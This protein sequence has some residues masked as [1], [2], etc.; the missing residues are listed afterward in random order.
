MKKQKPNP[1]L[2]PIKDVLASVRNAI[3]ELLAR[4]DK[5]IN[6]VGCGDTKFAD[7]VIDRFYTAVAEVNTRLAEMQRLLRP[8]GI[9][10][11]GEATAVQPAKEK[12]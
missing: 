10:K 12:P 7:K 8:A 2:A 9:E 1:E 3:R 5:V 6:A 11:V 4:T